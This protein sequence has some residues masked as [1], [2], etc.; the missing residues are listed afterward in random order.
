[1][2]GPGAVNGTA[3]RVRVT[4]RDARTKDFLPKVEVK[5]IGSA[6]PQFTSGVTDLR[7]VFQAEGPNGVITAVVRK[8]TNQYAFYRGSRS[9]NGSG[10]S[11]AVGGS[12][13]GGGR[14][15][16]PVKPGQQAGQALDANL[17]LQNESNSVQQIQRLQQRYV[18]AGDK[19][20]GAAAG[21][22]R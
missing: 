19:R 3:G 1:V 2:I 20:K 22:F 14:A 21:E 10:T 6:D 13:L 8:E 17:K 11:G 4:V 18:P 12:G 15:T 16:V 7:G 5:V 9:L